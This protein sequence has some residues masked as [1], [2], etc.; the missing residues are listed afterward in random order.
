GMVTATKIAVFPKSRLLAHMP[1]RPMP[2]PPV[3]QRRLQPSITG[4]D[5]EAPCAMGLPL[6]EAMKDVRL[7]AID[8]DLL[9]HVEDPARRRSALEAVVVNEQK[10]EPGDQ[11][12]V[13]SLAGGGG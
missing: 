8:A 12:D 6:D 3:A 5:S 13:N 11:L 1:L 7:L 9:E 2:R 4:L 10:L